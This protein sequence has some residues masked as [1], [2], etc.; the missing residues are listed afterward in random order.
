TATGAGAVVRT[1]TR[2]PGPHPQPWS[3]PAAAT[4]TATACRDRN[5]EPVRDR[6]N[7]L[8]IHA[9]G[10]PAG[11]LRPARAPAYLLGTTAIEARGE[12]ERAA[13]T[14]G[15]DSQGSKPRPGR[16]DLPA[17]NLRA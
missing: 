1:R 16:P 7:P 9:C 8:S 14:H 3:A 11:A 4:A 5:R 6:S 2:S 13:T 12:R 17:P 10:T 15:A